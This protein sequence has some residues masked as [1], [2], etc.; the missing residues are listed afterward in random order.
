MKKS[1]GIFVLTSLLAFLAIFFF[2]N[3][4]INEILNHKNGLLPFIFMVSTGFLMIALLIDLFLKQGISIFFFLNFQILG[5]F[6]RNDVLWPSFLIWNINY[7]A[8]IIILLAFF[9]LVF[10]VFYKIFNSENLFTK[11]WK[12]KEKINWSWKADSIFSKAASVA[13]LGVII[14]CL[15]YVPFR[16]VLMIGYFSAQEDFVLE[17]KIIGKGA[18]KGLM[19]K[20]SGYYHR[21]WKLDVNDK[22][23]KFW[24]FA[25]VA[26]S[27]KNCVSIDPEVGSL[28]KIKA[29]KGFL[30]TA[31]IDVLEIKNP[32]GKIRCEEH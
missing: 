14:I 23:E 11:N 26:S 8:I 10:I 3:D 4:V 32:D 31:I 1:I 18:D 6:L 28:L 21:F 7:F 12:G 24:V 27:N 2:C 5:Y 19:S 22:I 13:I 20:G 25:A 17:T 29:K 16:T 15:L 30:G 9:M